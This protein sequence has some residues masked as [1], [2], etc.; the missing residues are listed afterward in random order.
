MTALIPESV[1]QTILSFTFDYRSTTVGLVAIL[2]LGLLLIAR[3]I[4]RAHG[5]P[6]AVE[7]VDALNVAIYP[8][9][10]TFIGVVVVRVVSLI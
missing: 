2:I 7:R 6:R 10:L 9:L 3:E 4:I 5:G 1:R 8:L